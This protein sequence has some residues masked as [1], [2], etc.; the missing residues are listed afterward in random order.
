M[1]N[2]ICDFLNIKVFYAKKSLQRQ[3]PHFLLISFLCQMHGQ[4][5]SFVGMRQGQYCCPLKSLFF[6]SPRITLSRIFL[7]LLRLK[8]DSFA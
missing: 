6:V 2:F 5:D 4:I 7:F 8:L 3:C 1:L